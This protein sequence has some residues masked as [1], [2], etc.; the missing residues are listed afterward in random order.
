MAVTQFLE[1]ENIGLPYTGG[2]YNIYMIRTIAPLPE[3]RSNSADHHFPTPTGKIEIF[4]NNFSWDGQG[5]D[6]MSPCG[7]FACN[8]CLAQI[9]L[10]SG[11]ATV[12]QRVRM[13]SLLSPGP[14]RKGVFGITLIWLSFTNF[15]EV[16][17]MAE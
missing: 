16:S 7:A 15:T 4:R 11:N 8:G 1:E 12:C 2:P 3:T 17:R 5:K 6:E 14:Q 10:S 13:R 9:R